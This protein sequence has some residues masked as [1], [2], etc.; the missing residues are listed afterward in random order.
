[1]NAAMKSGER[2]HQVTASRRRKA[3][4][5]R[6]PIKPVNSTSA[7]AKSQVE[8]GEE[9]W[10]L[11]S[12]GQ[13]IQRRI[14]RISKQRWPPERRKLTGNWERTESPNVI[15]LT[16]SLFRQSLQKNLVDVS[17]TLAPNLDLHISG[18]PHGSISVKDFVSSQRLSALGTILLAC[19]WSHGFFLQRAFVALAAIADRLFGPS[20]AARATPPLRPP[21]R[22]RPTAAGVAEWSSIMSP[23]SQEQNRCQAVDDSRP[24]RLER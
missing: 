7:Q 12:L 19:N 5:T 3:L 21:N 6:G 4:G 2:G 1:M 17:T 15:A 16:A 10:L 23:V 13:M 8:K 22:P 18:L 24:S 9:F 14:G 20:T 11:P